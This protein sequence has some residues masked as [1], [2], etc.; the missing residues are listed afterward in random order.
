MVKSQS[1]EQVIDEGRHRESENLRIRVGSSGA[2]DHSHTD[3]VECSEEWAKEI[4]GLDGDVS[5]EIVLEEPTKSLSKVSRLDGTQQPEYIESVLVQSSMPTDTL[6][7]LDDLRYQECSRSGDPH[8]NRAGVDR[9]ESADANTVT[10]DEGAL[11][12]FRSTS[13]D[14]AMD[15]KA[16][17]PRSRS[18]DSLGNHEIDSDAIW[19]QPGSGI[20]SKGEP[21]SVQEVAEERFVGESVG[22]DGEIGIGGVLS[23]SQIGASCSEI[24]SLGP[25]ENKGIEVW[26]E[27][28]CSVE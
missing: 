3:C 17:S 20:P 27:R 19:I 10:V 22:T 7:D 26:F 18:G 14:L 9:V 12:A 28:V 25:D 13:D 8:V 1:L 2:D 4:D 23:D 5:A 24:D 6:G 15:A 16:G 11:Q 21:I